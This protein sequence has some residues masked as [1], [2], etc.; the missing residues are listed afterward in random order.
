MKTK[1]KKDTIF[2]D[3]DFFSYEKNLPSSY[4]EGEFLPKS[5]VPSSL[6]K[7]YYIFVDLNSLKKTQEKTHDVINKKKWTKLYKSI[8]C[9][10]TE[11]FNIK[12]LEDSLDLIINSYDEKLMASLKMKLAY[13]AHIERSEDLI[14]STLNLLSKYHEIKRVNANKNLNLNLN[15]D[16]G[17][18]S[19]DLI[20]ESSK[21][22]T[23]LTL[24]FCPDGKV[25]FF[26]Y[27]TDDDAH[28][29][30]GYMTHSGK[31]KSS[32]KIQSILNILGRDE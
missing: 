25:T 11:S 13:A 10:V 20:A 26:S 4:V 31:Y 17:I 14:Y 18:L 28:S 5:S 21:Y 1:E 12:T 15:I 8:Y 29:I 9:R 30:S 32:K 2:K 23:M 22:S 6:Q 27:D 16:T 24:S 3:F 7:A 19:L